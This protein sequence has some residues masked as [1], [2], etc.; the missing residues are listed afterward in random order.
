MRE[1]IV[2]SAS[3]SQILAIESAA[4]FRTIFPVTQ[5]LNAGVKAYLCRTFVTQ[6]GCFPS[7]WLFRLNPDSTR[8]VQC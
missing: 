1:G 6:N 3:V 7:N 5:A 2:S 8:A 4:F